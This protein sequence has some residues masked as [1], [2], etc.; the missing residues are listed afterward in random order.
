MN[1]AQA[2][3]AVQDI[4]DNF[5]CDNETDY[6]RMDAAVTKATGLYLDNKSVWG[7]VNRAKSQV[8]RVSFSLDD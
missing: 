8:E 6:Q 7:L 4:V 3:K 5:E 1:K 2:K